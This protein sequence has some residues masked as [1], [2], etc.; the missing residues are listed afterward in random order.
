V[1]SSDYAWQFLMQH[2]DPNALPVTLLAADGSIAAFPPRMFSFHCTGV[3]TKVTCR[4]SF[5]DYVTYT[6]TKK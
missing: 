2:V 5:G 1:N 3:P 6:P 4:N